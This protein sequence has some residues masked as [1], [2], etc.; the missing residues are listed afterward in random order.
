LPDG[1]EVVT[2]L[3]N[4]T[5]TKSCIDARL[6]SEEILELGSANADI[7]WRAT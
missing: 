2:K 3:E 1:T 5:L 6:E 7:R 4:P